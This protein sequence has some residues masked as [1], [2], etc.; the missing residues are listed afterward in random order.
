ML[1][2]VPDMNYVI[3]VRIMAIDFAAFHVELSFSLLANELISLPD[4]TSIFFLY[5]ICEFS[6]D[7]SMA[8]TLVDQLL[9]LLTSGQHSRTRATIATQHQLAQQRSGNLRHCRKE[10]KRAGRVM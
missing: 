5:S 6:R 3:V 9:N 1:V 4:L 8:T 2:Q 7:C 10:P